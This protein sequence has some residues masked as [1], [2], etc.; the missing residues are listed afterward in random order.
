MAGSG[1]AAEKRMGMVGS[2]QAM[3]R[4]ATVERMWM[5]GGGELPADVQRESG[6]QRV[7]RVGR[8]VCLLGVTDE[9]ACE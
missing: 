7:G 6:C 2:R 9:L 3:S 4:G 8:S 1:W 5:H